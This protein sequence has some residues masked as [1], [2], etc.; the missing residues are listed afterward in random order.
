MLHG[1]HL[2]FCSDTQAH[3][4]NERLPETLPHLEP[5]YK[6]Q[7]NGKEPE[8]PVSTAYPCSLHTPRL[9]PKE[10][11][12]QILLWIVFPCKV[13]TPALYIGKIPRKYKP[14]KAL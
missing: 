3:V 14:P 9:K 12:P 7:S 1:C 13:H 2:H 10:M 5:V 11:T 4:E 8:L 6:C